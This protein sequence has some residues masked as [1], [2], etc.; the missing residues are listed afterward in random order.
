MRKLLVVTL[1]LATVGGLT[2][3]VSTEKQQKINDLLQQVSEKTVELQDLKTKFD[4]GTLTAAEFKETTDS[5]KKTVLAAM[6]EIERMKDDGVGWLEMAGA[7]LLGVA[8]RGLPS[9]GPLGLL[10]QLF[11]ARRKED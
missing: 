2:A 1:L 5:V 9:K 10:T 7:T 3:C 11:A 8:A 4:A 6:D